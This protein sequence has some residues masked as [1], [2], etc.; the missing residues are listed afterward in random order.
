VVS[1]L[2]T[3]AVRE[4]LSAMDEAQRR[5]YAKSVDMLRAQGWTMVPVGLFTSLVMVSGLLMG[6]SRFVF[7][8]ELSFREALII[9]AYATLIV[10]PE[11]I[12]RALLILATDSPFVYLGPGMLLGEATATTFLGRMLVGINFFDLWQVGVMGC[13]LSAMSGVKVQ[14]T[15]LALA[16]LWLMWLV[17]GALLETMAVQV[18]PAEL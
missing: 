5:Q 8:G 11:W 4:K 3:P 18:A 13:G 12:V 2:D 1:D 6:I 15:T 9:K 10:C 14:R 16:A 17:G 7:Q